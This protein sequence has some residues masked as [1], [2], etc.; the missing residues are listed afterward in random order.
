MGVQKNRL[1]AKAAGAACCATT[2]EKKD[3]EAG[4]ARA[5]QSRAPTADYDDYSWV[6]ATWW[7]VGLGLRRRAD[8]AE[9]SVGTK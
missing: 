5:R 6:A 1:K 9:S 7:V 8:M 2:K 4:E 3:E